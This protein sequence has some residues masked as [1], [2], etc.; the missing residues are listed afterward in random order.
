MQFVFIVC[1]AE[2][3][4]NMLKSSSRPLA[5]ASYEAFSKNEERPG[6]SLPALFS[7]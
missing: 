2:G 5:F 3:Y 6:T 1:Q 7:P 4:R